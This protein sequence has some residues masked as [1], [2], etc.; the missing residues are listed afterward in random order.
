MCSC[1]PR[2]HKNIKKIAI[3]HNNT[4]CALEGKATVCINVWFKNLIE[5]YFVEYQNYKILRTM[6][7]NT[8]TVGFKELLKNQAISSAFLIANE[9]INYLLF[10]N[11]RTHLVFTQNPRQLSG[12]TWKHKICELKVCVELLLLHRTSSACI[13]GW[14]KSSSGYLFNSR[15]FLCCM[16]EAELI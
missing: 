12:K 8:K 9:K 13:L 14:W 5:R 1:I 3:I 16:N 11:V 10:T 7:E 15:N 6:Q 2:S 4:R